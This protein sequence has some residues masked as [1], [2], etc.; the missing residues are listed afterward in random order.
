MFTSLNP[1]SDFYH[2]E[3]QDF[4]EGG[5]CQFFVW[6]RSLYQGGTWITGY[7]KKVKFILVVTL[8][9]LVWV[10]LKVIKEG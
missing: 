2:N 1:E 7:K 8:K 10:M 4:A 6:L 5:T 9:R 3:V